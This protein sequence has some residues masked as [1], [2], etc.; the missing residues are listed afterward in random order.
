[1]TVSTAPVAMCDG[2]VQ[3]L[4]ENMSGATLLYLVTARDGQQVIYGNE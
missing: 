2:S 1:M 3:F 4:N